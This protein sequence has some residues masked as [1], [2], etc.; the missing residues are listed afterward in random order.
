M[1]I[2]EW[3]EQLELEREEKNRFFSEHWQSPIPP[4]ERAGFEGLEYYPPD[5]DFRFELELHK[6]KEKKIVGMTYTKGNQQDFLAWGEFRFR[7]G[8]KECVLQTYKANAEEDRLFILFKDATSSKETYGGGRYL[9][10]EP[11][12]HRTTEGKW[13]LDFNEAYNPWCVYSEE[14]TCPLVPL[15]NYLEAPIRAGEKKYPLN[16]AKGEE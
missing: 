10:L 11:G 1:E 6:H 14:Y 16:K 7:I 5:P 12:R 3:K 4:E 13:V 2:S 8:G 9:D 15:E